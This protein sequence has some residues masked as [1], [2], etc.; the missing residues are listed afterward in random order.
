MCSRQVTNV[1]RGR[2]IPAPWKE[3]RAAG[4]QDGVKLTLSIVPYA[5]PFVFFFIFSLPLLFSAYLKFKWA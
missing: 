1:G 5:A 2:Y 4:A 3:K